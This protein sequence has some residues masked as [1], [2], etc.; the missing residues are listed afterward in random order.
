MTKRNPGTHHVV[1]S[2]N[3]GWDVRRGGADRAYLLA[4][5]VH[6]LARHPLEQLVVVRRRPQRAPDRECGDVRL[7]EDDQVRLLLRGLPDQG[8]R[9]LRRFPGR[10]KHRRRMA[11][12]YPDHTHGSG[13][14]RRLEGW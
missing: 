9:L 1:P 6:G 14:Q 5:R 3:G 4:V 13:N 7:G 8:D 2:S 10:E 11:C 12:G